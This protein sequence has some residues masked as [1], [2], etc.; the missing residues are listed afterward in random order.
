MGSF[1]FDGVTFRVFPEDH[2][3]PHVHG[4]YQ[5]AVVILELGTDWRVRLADRN[6]AIQPRNAKRN[7]VNHILGVAGAHFDD[8]M[9]LWEDAHA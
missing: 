8:L 4:R 7:Q 3:P 1:R 5:G 2:D 6:D 9:E